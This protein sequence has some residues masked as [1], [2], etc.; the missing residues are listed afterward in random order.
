ML[1]DYLVASGRAT[2]LFPSLDQPV[3]L[4]LVSTINRKLQ[5]NFLELTGVVC[6]AVPC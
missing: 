3:I 6:T 4:L 5:F 2:Q 1:L